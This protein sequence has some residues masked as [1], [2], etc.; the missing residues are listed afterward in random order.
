MR[1]SIRLAG[2][3]SGNNLSLG[4]EKMRDGIPTLGLD[5]DGTIDENPAF[6]SLLTRFYPG[7]VVVITLREDGPLVLGNFGIRYDC[8]I[9]VPNLAAKA[10]VVEKEGVDVFIGDQDEELCPLP[11]S[12]TALKIRGGGNF[13]YDLGKWLYGAKTG[14]LVGSTFHKP[15]TYKPLIRRRH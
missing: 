14:R 8:V 2:H 6:F 4:V 11:P 12:C 15:S 10:A 1:N 9:H 3:C 13:D 5:I 7:R